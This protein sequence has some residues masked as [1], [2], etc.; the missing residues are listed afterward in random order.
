M[1]SASST[2]AD[3]V[4]RGW[5]EYEEQLEVVVRRLSGEQLDQRISPNLRS[6]GEIVAHIITG[7]AF[8]FQEVLGERP[9]DPEL[10]KLAEWLLRSDG[11]LTGVG[12]ARGLEQTAALMRDAIGRWTPE[13]LAEQI[14]LPWIG[15]KHPITR[16]WVLWHE[17]E[18]DLHHGGELSQ[19]LG[20]SDANVLLPPPPPD[21]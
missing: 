3:A 1:G 4:V 13:E 19:T 2:I 5:L 8:W 9:G 21:D 6:A 20:L 10:T 7:R 14:V 18:H 11:E 17:V 16:A 15:P 12:L